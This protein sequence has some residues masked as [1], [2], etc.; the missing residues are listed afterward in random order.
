[1]RRPARSKHP[2]ADAD[3]NPDFYHLSMIAPLP[4]GGANGPA[5][6]P[7]PS[8]MHTSMGRMMPGAATLGPNNNAFISA[9]PQGMNPTAAFSFAG[10]PDTM[11]LP[12]KS[13]DVSSATAVGGGAGLIAPQSATEILQHH[14]QSQLKQEFKQGSDGPVARGT[15]GLN[16]GYSETEGDVKSSTG[17]GGADASN[18]FDTLRMTIKERTDLVRQ[19]KEVMGDGGAGGAGAPGAMRTNG[20][21]DPG[22]GPDASI[23]SK[24]TQLSGAGGG[25]GQQRDAAG[26]QVGLPQ[27]SNASSAGSLS[28]H[29]MQHLLRQQAAA[30]G[31]TGFPGMGTFASLNPAMWGA[32]T[33]QTQY[34]QLMC[35]Q[36]QTQYEQLMCAQNIGGAAG[37]PGMNP[38]LAGAPS[39]AAANIGNMGRMASALQNHSFMAQIQ[40][41]QASQQQYQHDVGNATTPKA[42]EL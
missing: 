26:G 30:G 8:G 19:L 36:S 6:A 14:I 1:M 13:R 34:E 32:Q 20:I 21:G 16:G 18:D 3:V 29:Q 28:S 40:K 31:L 24:A 4:N 12:G 10:A 25:P 22:G 41:Q 17:V 7:A 23:A 37:L 38:S 11:G 15:E 2:H 42:E 27:V 5:P 33:S 35:A 39:G 9:S